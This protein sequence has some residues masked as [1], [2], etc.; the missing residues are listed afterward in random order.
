MAKSTA[1]LTPAMAEAIKNTEP[2]DLMKGGPTRAALIRRGLVHPMDYYPGRQGV[3][4][5]TGLQARAKLLPAPVSPP[6][7]TA[8]PAYDPLPWLQ[9]LGS[10]EL[11][12][13]LDEVKADEVLRPLVEQVIN[14][15]LEASAPEQSADRYFTHGCGAD[16]LKRDAQCPG[17][18]HR[19]H[20]RDAEPCITQPLP[21][22][23]PGEAL[24]EELTGEP[25]DIGAVPVGTARPGYRPSV[26]LRPVSGEVVERASRETF[27]AVGA[28][29]GR[30]EGKRVRIACMDGDVFHQ[31]PLMLVESHP[32][33]IMDPAWTRP[34]DRTVNLPRALHMGSTVLVDGCRVYQVY[35]HQAYLTPGLMPVR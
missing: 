29:W 35:A 6:A 2:G 21:Q 19:G 33:Q 14:E 3:L 9:S 5:E 32:D 20:V 28:E 17:T 10:Q 16:V 7:V 12:K 26:L 27:V 31:R 24:T 11:I 18:P 1:P 30:L 13:L 25:V 15:R 8:V 34:G 4:T 23:T 22:R